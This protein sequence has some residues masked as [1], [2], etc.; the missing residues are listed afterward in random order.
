MMTHIALSSALHV[1][2]FAQEC[3]VLKVR[4]GVLGAGR[5]G[6]AR[7]EALRAD[8]RAVVVGGWRGDL[9]AA[10]LEG[11]SSFE[12]DAQHVDAVAVCSPDTYH[13]SQVHAALSAYRHVVCEYPIASSAGEASSLF[14]L[15]VARDRVRTLNASSCS[16][17]RRSGFETLRWARPSWAARCDSLADRARARVARACG[18][19]ALAAHH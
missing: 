14:A 17:Q 12:E 13:A 3:V 11:F 19:R 7:V 8:P 5:A 9:E 10:G 15:A 2:Q 16:R 18:H 4:W 1:S 6:G